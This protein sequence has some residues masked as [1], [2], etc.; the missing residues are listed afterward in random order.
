VAV[1]FNRQPIVVR[2]VVGVAEIAV[3]NTATVIGELVVWIEFDGAIQIFNRPLV[4]PKIA[5][6]IAAIVVG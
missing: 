6:G 3:G 1:V 5:V 2:I 4:L